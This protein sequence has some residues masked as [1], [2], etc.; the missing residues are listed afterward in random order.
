MRDHIKIVGI[1][2]IVMGSITALVGVVVLLM[3]GTIAGFVAAS[4]SSLDGTNYQN[5]A[6]AAPIVAMIGV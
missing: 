5:G 3:M 2:N 6:I 4:I 1:L